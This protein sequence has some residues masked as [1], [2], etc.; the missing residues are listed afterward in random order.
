[1]A[2]ATLAIWAPEDAYAN[3]DQNQVALAIEYPNV[4]VERA[5]LPTLTNLI[6][7][8]Y[9]KYLLTYNLFIY[10]DI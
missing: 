4:V 8:G 7:L 6:N 3:G 5:L 2:K 10:S 9:T 1:M